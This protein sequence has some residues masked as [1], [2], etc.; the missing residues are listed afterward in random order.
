MYKFQ[1]MQN[2]LS[3]IDKIWYEFSQKYLQKHS[4]QKIELLKYIEEIQLILLNELAPLTKDEDQEVKKIASENL[5]VAFGLIN[6]IASN[7]PKITAE[8]IKEAEESL[9]ISM[10]KL[11]SN[12]KNNEGDKAIEE[13]SKLDQKIVEIINTIKIGMFSSDKQINSKS[14]E[15]Y[16]KVYKFIKGNN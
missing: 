5:Q 14:Q 10:A 13:F 2:T 6:S 15:L 12:K 11:I 7:L 1:Q 8:E 9:K 4:F 3:K 16:S